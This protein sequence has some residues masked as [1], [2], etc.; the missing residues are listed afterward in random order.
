MWA[1]IWL[2]NYANQLRRRLTKSK[3]EYIVY[4]GKETWENE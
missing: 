2:K 1:E 4:S 3:S